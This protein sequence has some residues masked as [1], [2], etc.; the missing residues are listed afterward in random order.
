MK[1]NGIGLTVSSLSLGGGGGPWGKGSQGI[2]TQH[3]FR[4]ESINNITSDSCVCVFIFTFRIYLLRFPSR[5][6]CLNQIQIHRSDSST[7]SAHDKVDVC[8]ITA[9]H[10]QIGYVFPPP[11]SRFKNATAQ[12]VARYIIGLKKLNC[13]DNLNLYCC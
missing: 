9:G 4:S 6:L 8:G 2:Y 7:D 1:S 5:K 13:V 3:T 11:M 12:C 10:N